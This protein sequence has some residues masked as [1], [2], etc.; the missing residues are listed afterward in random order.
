MEFFFKCWNT[1][2]ARLMV[3]LVKRNTRSKADSGN[4]CVTNGVSSLRQKA[5]VGLFWSALERLGQQGC[6]FVVQIV[7]ARILMPEAFGLIAMVTVFIAISGAVVDSGLGLALIQRKSVSEADLSTVFHFNV[8]ASLI[9]IGA[10][11]AVAPFVAN[12]YEQVE[13]TMILRILGFGLV[14]G[15]VGS[16]QT[17]ILRRKLEFRKL[18]WV[19]TP[20]TLVSGVIGI[21]MA[22]RGYGVWS[23]VGQALSQHAVSSMMLW[24]QTRWLPRF[25]FDKVALSAMLP[26]GSRLAASQI[27]D[28]GFQNL[29]VL[30][31]GRMFSPVDVGYFQ[32]AF[33]FQQFP[34][35]N[36]QTL[37]SNVSFP[38][39]SSIQ[40]EPARMRHVVR[41][42]LHLAGL[43]SFSAMAVLAA[44]AEPMVLV[45]LGEKWLPCAPMLQLLC[46]VGALYPVHAT[47]LSLLQAIGRSDLFLRLEVIKKSLTLVNVAVTYRF[48][49][50]AMIAG[51]VVTSVLALAINTHYT[52]RFVDY[53][54]ADQ[55][56]AL[57]SPIGI[58]LCLF[59]VVSGL[60][61]WLPAGPL[62]QL[63][64]AGVASAAVLLAALRIMPAPVRHEIDALLGR[65]SWGPRISGLVLGR[66]PT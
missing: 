47:N 27:V 25:T 45:L 6:V 13:L 42:S 11:W 62:V 57:F 39:L 65:F 10:L 41:T 50:Q 30:V 3:C 64:L 22:L 60:N 53:G 66:W 55:L 7:L 29:Y 46:V 21:T 18:F 24:I 48:G 35:G 19:S 58:G 43:I 28:R 1:G 14:L 61:H 38:L 5:T 4:F 23:L 52:R 44:V 17:S 15:A 51:M 2:N 9:M 54:L 16:V 31:I 32:R 8:L 63:V 36:L 40:H 56:A 20:S 26:Y 12:F 59:A 33:S 34:M 37:I 49:I